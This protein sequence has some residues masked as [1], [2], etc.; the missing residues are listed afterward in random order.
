MRGG[1]GKT[2]NT[3]CGVLYDGAWGA[4]K[5]CAMIRIIHGL[6]EHTWRKAG[7][8]LTPLAWASFF[9]I[10]GPITRVRLKARIAGWQMLIAGFR[11]SACR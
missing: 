6:H 11:T 9:S 7:L 1:R 3:I 2:L 8:S 4:E 10:L 5:R